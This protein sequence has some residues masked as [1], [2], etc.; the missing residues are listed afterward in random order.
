MSGEADAGP[1]TAKENIGTLR[2]LAVLNTLPDKQ[3]EQVELLNVLCAAVRAEAAETPARDQAYRIAKSEI[4]GALEDKYDHDTAWGYLSKF[5]AVVRAEAVAEHRAEQRHWIEVGQQLEAEKRVAIA[6]RDE[7]RRNWQE[8]EKRTAQAV[9]GERQRIA[10]MLQPANYYRECASTTA[11]PLLR[12]FATVLA[13]MAAGS[14][15]VATRPEA[16]IRKHDEECG[17][18]RQCTNLRCRCACHF[19]G[20]G[21]VATPTEPEHRPAGDPMTFSTFCVLDGAPWTDEGCSRV[22][23]A[24]PVATPEPTCIHPFAAGPHPYHS[25]RQREELW[26]PGPVATPAED[27][28][29]MTEYVLL[30]ERCTQ[31]ECGDRIRYSELTDDQNTH[32][33][34]KPGVSLVVVA[35]VVTP[36]ELTDRRGAVW[37]RSEEN[38][39][40]WRDEDGG[41]YASLESIEHAYG[42]TAPAASV[43]SVATPTEPLDLENTLQTKRDAASPVPAVQPPTFEQLLTDP[44]EQFDTRSELLPAILRYLTDHPRDDVANALLRSIEEHRNAPPAT[45]STSHM[46]RLAE[47]PQHWCLCRGGSEPHQRGVVG[48]RNRPTGQPGER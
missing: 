40:R 28:Q 32:W 33:H 30:T 11:S 35:S 10:E 2:L 21:L 31:R 20:V 47:Q 41:A 37:R 19:E 46:T 39:A 1:M 13:G 17:S 14:V 3:D 25:P 15:P 12:E 9:A 4:L 7:Y 44:L 45:A 26:C 42:P 38:P 16:P 8:A 18:P 27:R 34:V 36:T 6:E 22:V 23:A 43:A 29:Q 24:S 5:A 48:C